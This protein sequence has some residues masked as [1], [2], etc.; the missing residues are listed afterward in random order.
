MTRL[1]PMRINSNQ[2]T[3]L[4]REQIG[5]GFLAYRFSEDK[6]EV[7]EFFVSENGELTRRDGTPLEYVCKNGGTVR[8]RVVSEKI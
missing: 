3:R 6:V 2:I 7:V 1:K 8:Y 4:F 5:N